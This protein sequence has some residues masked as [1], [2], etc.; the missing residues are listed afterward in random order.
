MIGSQQN[1]RQAFVITKQNIIARLHF[2][3]EI[4]LEQQR[5]DFRFCDNHFQLVGLADHAQDAIG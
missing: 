4:G 5:F 1:L 3:N 2:F